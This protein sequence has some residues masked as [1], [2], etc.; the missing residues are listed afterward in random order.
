MWTGVSGFLM[1][2]HKYDVLLVT[3]VTM[4]QH[5]YK[6]NLCIHTYSTINNIY[7]SQSILDYHNRRQ[8]QLSSTTPLT[9]SVSVSVHF[10]IPSYS[11]HF[12]QSS[13]N[14]NSTSV[15]NSASGYSFKLNKPQLNQ[16]GTVL[17]YSFVWLNHFFLF[18][19]ISMW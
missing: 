2:G 8:Q 7:R 17:L 14:K 9:N 4:H 5:V 6:H 12:I 10:L 1:L 3:M 18:T 11:H 19:Y 15:K 16:T 13:V